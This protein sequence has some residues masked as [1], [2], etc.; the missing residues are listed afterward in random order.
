MDFYF[1]FIVVFIEN[2]SKYSN[3]SIVFKYVKSQIDICDLDKIKKHLI[4]IDFLN[5]KRCIILIF[6]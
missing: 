5:V 3:P 4:F 1:S 2:D 6:Q